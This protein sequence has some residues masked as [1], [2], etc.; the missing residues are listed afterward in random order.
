MDPGMDVVLVLVGSMSFMWRHDA[1]VCA[2]CNVALTCYIYHKMT[3][4]VFE[5]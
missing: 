4:E 3:R 2:R 5:F 1:V